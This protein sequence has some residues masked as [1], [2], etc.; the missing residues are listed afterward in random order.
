MKLNSLYNSPLFLKIIF[1]VS[2]FVIFFISGIT[3]KHLNTVEKS[4]YY[5][6]RSYHVSLELERLISYIKDAETGQRGYIISR[7]S[8]FLVPYI[9]SKEKIETSFN[10][11]KELTK[12][13]PEQLQ[14]VDRLKFLINKRKNYLSKNIYLVEEKGIKSPEFVKNLRIGKA[15]MDSIRIHIDEMDTIEDLLFKR[16]TK[17]FNSTIK[18]TPIIVY[19]TLLTTL[20]LIA[21][22]FVKISRDLLSLKISNDKLVIAD[23]SSKMAEIVGNFGSWQFDIDED[24]YIF[25]DNE[26][27]LLGCEPNSFEASLE[28][29]L[30]YVHPEDISYVQENVGKM[31]ENKDLPSFT[32]RIIRKDGQIRYL[33]GLGKLIIDK[34]G[35]KIIL[36]T[37]NDITDEFTATQLIEDRNQELEANNKELSAF[38]YVASHDLQEPLRKIQTFISR[39]AEKEANN[40]SDS[41]K[42]YMNRIQIASERMRLLIDDLLQFSRTNKAEKVFEETNLNA[43]FE[44]A[45]QELS[46]N[47]E[48]KKATINCEE[49]PVAKVIPFQIQQLF[50]NLINNSLKYSKEDT[51]PTINI[52]YEK[53][54]SDTDNQ[55]PSNNRNKFHKITFKDNGIGFEKEYNERI[56]TLFS[57]LHNR[58]EYSGTGI[59][60]SICKKIAE[61]HKGYIF[62]D[63]EPSVGAVFTVY[64]PII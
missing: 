9:N 61:N 58:N 10:K 23:E 60:L 20:V 34:S 54:T 63:G 2:I 40:F 62:G 3:F 59:G 31:L 28:N 35:K 24:K 19:L 6:T 42:D 45:K 4:S 17:E 38:N 16:R 14:N 30:Q 48:D 7:D 29:F 57:R 46:Q 22:A 11:L 1:V 12:D 51:T 52:R 5:V 27:R 13:N 33:K 36:G 41:G 15:T 49:L 26:Y 56:F 25:S 53:V 18:F 44:N 47:I 39:I 8:T 64:L 55:I 32:Y 50:V 21:F 37:S 43:L